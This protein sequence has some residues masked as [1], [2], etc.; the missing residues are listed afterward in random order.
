M[1]TGLIEEIGCVRAI[2]KRAGYQ[3][4]TVGAQRVLE[5]VRTGDSITLNGACHTV[6]VFDKD[7][8]TVE[9]VD[10]TLRRTTLGGLRVGSP[11][12]LERAMKLGDRLGGH[13]V[14]GHVDG[15]GR[16]LQRQES[17]DNTVFQIGLPEELAPY[18]AEKGS[19]T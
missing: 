10:E 18:V 17:A 11:V 15:V 1:F 16:I 8:F 19:I 6:V 3:Q 12:N 2:R 9:S 13:L 7:G 14:A 4:T 5:D